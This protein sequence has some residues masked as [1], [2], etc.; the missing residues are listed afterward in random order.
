MLIT[1]NDILPR[2]G[3]CDL[4]IHRFPKPGIPG[5]KYFKAAH[6]NSAQAGWIPLPKFSA[7]PHMATKNFPERGGELTPKNIRISGTSGAIC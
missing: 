4:K 7:Y 3:K 6:S 5:F 1:A 2:W